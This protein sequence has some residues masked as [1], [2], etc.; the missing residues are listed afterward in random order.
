MENEFQTERE[1]F[2]PEKAVLDEEALSEFTD[3]D[4]LPQDEEYVDRV[5]PHFYH[6]K[7]FWLLVILAAVGTLALAL[8]P[9]CRSKKKG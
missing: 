7:S 5:K 8:L 4:D 1:L 6:R 3:P 9:L 2:P